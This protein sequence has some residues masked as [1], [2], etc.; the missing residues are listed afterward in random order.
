MTGGLMTPAQVVATAFA[1]S[2]QSNPAPSV[3]VGGRNRFMAVVGRF[4]P[5]RT[6]IAVAKTLMRS[7]H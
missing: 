2:E 7:D 3:I 6:L 1:A 5:R 4:V